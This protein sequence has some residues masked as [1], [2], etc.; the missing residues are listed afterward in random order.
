[1]ILGVIEKV[2]YKE[3]EYTSHKFLELQVGLEGMVGVIPCWWV[4]WV[5]ADARVV[6]CII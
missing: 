4:R 6:S 1:M 3:Y 2:L 5:D